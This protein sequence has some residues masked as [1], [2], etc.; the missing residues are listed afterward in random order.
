MVDVEFG[1]GARQGALDQEPP[2]VG[3]H[4]IEPPVAA[5]PSRERPRE[6]AWQVL[7]PSGCRR[8][9]RHGL[10]LKRHFSHP[11][12]VIHAKN[13]RAPKHRPPAFQ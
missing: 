6:V 13:P 9:V 10:L 1:H 4:E 12:A 3:D 8:Y 5:R 11:L 7:L 2:T